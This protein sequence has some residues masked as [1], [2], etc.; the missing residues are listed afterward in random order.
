LNILFFVSNLSYPPIEGA[1]ARTLEL[2][3]VLASRG[4]SVTLAG[5][6]KSSSPFD[7]TLY[8]KN[9]QNII[10]RNFREY[11][12]NYISQALK[13]I[14]SRFEFPSVD[15]V[16]FEGFAVISCGTRCKSPKILSLIDPWALRQKRKSE[17]E[18]KKIKKIVYR[19]G[20]TISKWLERRYLKTYSSVHVVSPIDAI[21][22]KESQ[23]LS[24]VVHI[25]V[26]FDQRNMFPQKVDY[27][28]D[29]KLKIVF[30]AD[31]NVEY[32]L[33][34]LRWYVSNVHQIISKKIDIDL[35]ILGRASK[36]YILEKVPSLSKT[37]NVHVIE[38]T[39]NLNL[40]LS[41][42]DLA[43]LPDLSGT[44]LKNR[45]L[46]AMALGLPTLGS[47]YAFEGINIGETSSKVVCT[48][49]QD[50]LNKIIEL[51]I[52]IEQRL[53]LATQLKAA[54]SNNYDAT[55]IALEWEK[56]YSATI[57]KNNM[58]ASSL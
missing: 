23:N 3:D 51:S 22:L 43:V 54:I 46:H 4:H 41:T 57:E 20:A 26:S 44:G 30:W 27:S 29:S 28:T 49:S 55:V 33:E 53:D 7:I 32:L 10:I 2:I 47:K 31:V 6:V 39:D 9:H 48:T 17:A 25:P 40:F 35:Y 52:S 36:A 45:T 1:H 56:L 50:Y 11:S 16:H 42:M 21:A 12:G 34:S 18:N 13:N 14:F 8:K 19:L 37:L 24:N 15:I 58:E 38:W 5:F